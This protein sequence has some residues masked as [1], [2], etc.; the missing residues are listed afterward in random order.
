ML[1][2][3]AIISNIRIPT[4]LEPAYISTTEEALTSPGPSSIMFLFT[5]DARVNSVLDDDGTVVHD[6]GMI[7]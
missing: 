3:D 7:L 4:I 1:L 2:G 5:P 6:D